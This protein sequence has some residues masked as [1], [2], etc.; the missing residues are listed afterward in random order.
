MIKLEK[1]ICRSSSI[2]LALIVAVFVC[3]A[4]WPDAQAQEAQGA[5][6]IEEIVV[7]SRKREEALQDIPDT[8]TVLTEAVIE[9]AGIDS[10]EDISLLVPGMNVMA[11][12]NISSKL[13]NVRGIMMQREMDPSVS[14][15]IDGV[16]L[17]Q[18]NQFSQALTD[19]QQVE[20]LKGPQGS[21]W[22]RGSIA[23]AI[24]ITTKAP[25]DEFEGKVMVGAGQGYEATGVISGPITDTLAYRIH[26]NWE[27]HDGTL[28]NVNG[29]G[30][31][32]AAFVQR[33][34]A[35]GVDAHR[36]FHR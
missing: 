29:G 21:L 36:E 1:S 11:S 26:A 14:V 16:Q 28:E 7:T 9:H 6:V 10:I 34:R 24:N 32:S 20:V 27:K 12:N 8:I 17:S 25:S 22:G 2:P 33:P 15:I 3:P 13:V 19:I 23:G 4:S 35:A 5:D 18:F 30:P 31:R